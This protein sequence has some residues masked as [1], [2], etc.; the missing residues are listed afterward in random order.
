MAVYAHVCS[1]ESHRRPSDAY[2][3][4][5]DAS[6]RGWRALVGELL[7][8]GV[9]ASEA[10]SRA[11]AAFPPPVP[12]WEPCPGPDFDWFAAYGVTPSVIARPR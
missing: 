7:A 10:M 9:D 2:L 1:R 4:A 5:V 12:E 3:D 6:S 8:A 11:E